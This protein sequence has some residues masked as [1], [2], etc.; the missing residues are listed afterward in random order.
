MN[1]MIFREK[2]EQKNRLKDIYLEE[3]VNL[4]N[5]KAH[6]IKHTIYKCAKRIEFDSLEQMKEFVVENPTKIQCINYLHIVNNAEHKETVNCQVNGC[7]YIV[8]S[9]ALFLVNFSHQFLM[10]TIPSHT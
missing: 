9:K 1:R 10:E 7:L 2:Y 4:N 6:T 8:H 5:V 3:S